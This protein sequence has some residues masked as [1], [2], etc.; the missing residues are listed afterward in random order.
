MGRPVL[1]TGAGGQLGRYT[2]SALEQAGYAVIGLGRSHGDGV[3]LVAD[4]QDRSALADV[5][6]HHLPSAIIHAAAFTD[7]DGCE[8]EPD[9]ADGVNRQGAANVAEVAAASDIW[10]VGISTDYVFSGDDGAPYDEVAPPDPISVYGSSKLAGERSILGTSPSFAV[11]RTSWIYGGAGKHF[12]RT[13][14]ELVACHEQME[15]VDDERSSPTF[16]GDLAH[17]LVQLL[18]LRPSGILHLTNAGSASRYEFARSI[19]ELAGQDPARIIPTS[20]EAFLAKYPLPAKRPRNSTLSNKR[21]ADIGICLPDWRESLEQY[22]PRLAQ[23]IR[24]HQP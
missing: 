15:V 4:V 20:T 9:V 18:K 13:V 11:V 7:V 24:D 12:P 3:N 23:E 10:M 21:A 5:V 6:T 14:L 19:V 1:L 16:A 17:S 2:R 8:R 22:V